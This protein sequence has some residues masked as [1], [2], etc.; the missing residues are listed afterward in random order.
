[1]RQDSNRVE[2]FF[3]KFK[4]AQQEAGYDNMFHKDYMVNLLYKV[5]NYKIVERIFSIH[6][7]PTTFDKWKH[8]TIQIDQNIH[9]FREIMS[10]NY[11]SGLTPQFQ[12]L[13]PQY[14]NQ[15]S[16]RPAPGTPS[17]NLSWKR[18]TNGDWSEMFQIWM[19][20]TLCKRMQKWRTDQRSDW[21]RC[22]RSQ[23]H[24]QVFQLQWRRPH[25]LWKD[26]FISF[27][28][29]HHV[30]ILSYLFVILFSHSHSHG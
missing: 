20:R 23:E 29:S 2:T 5:L 7:L 24:I 25:I 18:T 3:A 28:L 22:S 12:K 21:R 1:M 15:D 26:T 4:M 10:S 9:M 16:M 19:T 17:N 30:F 8:H 11:W 6:P 14:S 27:L 13:Q